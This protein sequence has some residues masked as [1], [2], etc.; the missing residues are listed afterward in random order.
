MKQTLKRLLSV[1]L[2]LVLLVGLF[3]AVFAEGTEP[4]NVALGKTVTDGG[5]GSN[6]GTYWH[7][8]FLTDGQN[9]D[10]SG[11]NNVGWSSTDPVGQYE[12]I[13]LTVDLDGYYDLSKIVLL[14]T[15]FDAAK[16]YPTAYT[17]SVSADGEEWE[18]VA[19]DTRETIPAVEP[20][21]YTFET[22]TASY[23]RVTI[24]ET[25][26]SMRVTELP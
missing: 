2:V 21:E 9:H 20:Q 3:P 13:N 4:T 6:D 24:T 26:P 8:S 14:P 1:L 17:I 7:T 5:K 12:E 25:A 23:V 19:F 15:A 10:L 18:E 16:F 11:G 22:K